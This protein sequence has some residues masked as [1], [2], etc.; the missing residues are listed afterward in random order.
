MQSAGLIS[1]TI[2][3]PQVIKNFGGL[4]DQTIGLLA[5]LPFVAS[6]LVLLVCSQTS[7][8][9]GDRRWHVVAAFTV[10]ACALAG[11]ALSGTAVEAMAFLVIA[12]GAVF[13]V[14]AIFWSMIIEAFAGKGTALALGLAIVTTLGGISGFVGPYAMGLLRSAFGS[15]NSALLVTAGFYLLPAALIALFGTE[16]RLSAATVPAVRTR[17]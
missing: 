4:D 6:L 16:L 3:L 13:G 1:L 12:I 10:G 15:F 9:L 5:A 11:S 8:R 14:Q 2:W 17:F 7:D